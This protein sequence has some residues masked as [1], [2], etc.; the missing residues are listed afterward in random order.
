MAAFKE[1]GKLSIWLSAFHFTVKSQR[2]TQTRSVW[3]RRAH[4]SP[5]QRA[6]GEQGTGQGWPAGKGMRL[7]PLQFFLGTHTGHGPEPRRVLWVGQML[8][9]LPFNSLY[10][11]G[12]LGEENQQDRPSSPPRQGRNDVRRTLPSTFT[13]VATLKMGHMSRS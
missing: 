8:I 13:C 9:K 5:S 1:I 6:P 10:L 4:S 12:S 7:Q 3:F 2:E 11:R